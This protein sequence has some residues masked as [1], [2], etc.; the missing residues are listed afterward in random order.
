M[1]ISADDFGCSEAVNEAICTCFDKGL[2]NRTAIMIN[3]PDAAKA[4]ELA[5]EHGFFG[6]VGLHIN[7]TDGKALSDVCASSELCDENGILKGTLCDLTKK[8]Q[9]LSDAVRSALKA[10]IESQMKAFC[11]R[12]FSLKYADVHDGLLSSPEIRALLWEL[13]PRYGFTSGRSIRSL[14]EHKAALKKERE[15]DVPESVETTAYACTLKEF[16]SYPDKEAVRY[17]LEIITHPRLEEGELTDAGELFPTKEWIR[18]NK[19]YMEDVTGK[20]LRLFIGFIHAHTG[21]AMTSLVNFL[22]ALDTD[23]YDVDVMFYEKKE[24]R[25]GIKEEIQLLPQG[26]MHTSTDVGNILRK[27]ISPSYMRARVLDLYYKK[28]KHNRRKA[29]QIM[30]KEGCKYSRA[31]A[32]SYDVAISY[33]VSWCLNYVMNRVKAKKKIIWNH[34]EYGVSGLD[35]NIDKKELDRADALVFVSEDC[36]K[37]Y[38]EKHP[39]HRDKCNFMPNIMSS[40]YVRN[41]GNEEPDVPEAYTRGTMRFLTVARVNFEHK[42]LDRAVT[43]F[44]RLKEEGLL[45]P[46][47][48]L[49]IGD[50]WDVEKLCSM[51]KENGL[52]DHI[53]YIGEKKNP[54]PYYKTCDAFLLPSRHEGKPMVV[55]ES[56]IMGAPPVV[57]AYT[58]AKEQIENGVD[59]LVF[60]NSTEALYQGLKELVTHPEKLEDMKAVVRAK[61]YGNEADIRIFDELIRNIL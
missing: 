53:F 57:T 49:I 31:I 47:R 19:L 15:D 54:I 20:K 32:K 23:K 59:G 24:G 42:G 29:I 37:S 58:S 43:A 18:E 44:A 48:W 34:V 28:V 11:D 27:A 13:F 26:K 8:P 16:S 51:V 4:E 39:E 1:I 40:A 2:V 50:G 21:G 30:S 60:D 36:K 41:R 9:A 35:F 3:M 61:D 46:V 17:D 12:G 45:D 56:Y 7:L 22:N 10:E 5:K 38:M 33:E 55:T 25:Y 6:N 14:P 52:T